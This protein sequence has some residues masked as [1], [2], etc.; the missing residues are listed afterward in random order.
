[1]KKKYLLLATSLFVIHFTMGQSLA[2]NTDGSI[3]NASALLDVKSTAKGILIPRMTKTERN[4]IASPATGLLIFQNAPDSA[5]FYYYD[6]SKWNWVAALN[7]NAD[8][9]AWKRNGNS[10]TNPATHFIGNIDDQPLSFRQNNE[11]LG[12]WNAATANYFI[13]TGAGENITTTENI[14]IGDSALAKSASATGTTAIGHYSLKEN[15]SGNYNV[16]AGHMSLLTNT[17]GSANTA[18]GTWTL[19]SNIGA[20]ANTAIGASAMYFNTAGANN[21]A[22]GFHAVFENNTGNSNTGVGYEALESNQTGNNNVALG[23]RSLYSNLFGYSNVAIGREALRMNLTNNNLVAIGDSAL[24]NNGSGSSNTAVGSKSLYTNTTG[25]YNTGTGFQSLYQNSTGTNNTAMGSHA[26]T[27]NSTGSANTAVGSF[28]LSSLTGSNYNVAVGDSAARNLASGANN[29][30]VGTWAMKDHT[31]GHQNTAIG[32]F[33]M[34]ERESGSYNSALGAGALWNTNNDLNTGIGYQ[35]GYVNISGTGNTFL[36]SYADAGLNNLTNATAIGY[37][38]RVDTSNAIVLG[39]TSTNV[40]IGLAK[41][42]QARLTVAATGG[43]VGIFGSGNTGI[44]L[45]QNSPAVA[46]NQYRDVSAANVGKYMGN[47]YAWVNYLNTATGVMYWN[48]IPSGTA[49][50]VVGAETIRMTMS[51]TGS[52]GLGVVP[53]GN[54]QLQFQNSL[55]NRKVV[56]LEEANTSIDFYGF[57]TNTGLLRYQV[58]AAGN[59]HSFWAGNSN[60]FNI[61]GN[62]NATL[63]GTLT[64]LSDSRMKRNIVPINNVLGSLKKINAYTYFWKDETKDPD[65]HIGLL[66]QEVDNIFPQLVKKDREGLLSVSYSGFVPLLIKGMQEQQNQIDELKKELAELKAKIK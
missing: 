41:P 50:A 24:Y 52:L 57:G 58:P 20:S 16:A 10:G 51:M 42:Y 37:F 65:Q 18:Y 35:T 40:G 4:S 55:D 29:V 32:N 8:T 3:A 21:T 11:W 1:M 61:F 7:G 22:V 48:S 34:G 19:R 15:T 62:G 25:T 30:I 47:G 45:Q 59:L 28:S 26:L 43:T 44:S 49:N 9:L 23:F 13:G 36:G 38:A 60:I 39:S 64:E 46:F 31:F 66:A 63:L 56:L 5:G 54:G 14:A 53:N 33:A 12:K 6:G 17:T 2:V 27:L